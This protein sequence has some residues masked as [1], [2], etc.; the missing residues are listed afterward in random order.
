MRGRSSG[1]VAPPVPQ[2]LSSSIVLPKYSR[3]GRLTNSTLTTGRKGRDEPRNAVHDQARFTFAFAQ[4][5]LGALPLVDVRQQHAP[6]NDVAAR[7]TKRKAVVLEPKIDAVRP[8]EPLHNLVGAAGD[9]RLCEG[10]DDERKVL[11][12][13]GVVRPPIV[14]TLQGSVRCIRGSGD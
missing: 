10:L 13:N 1:C 5:V 7:I 14:S 8:P 6:A 12:V 4:R 3:I 2:R 11:R 9:D